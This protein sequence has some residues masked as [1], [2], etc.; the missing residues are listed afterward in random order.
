MH[1]RMQ[2]GGLHKVKAAGWATAAATGLQDAMNAARVEGFKA[3]VTATQLEEEMAEFESAHP[4]SAHS[5]QSV[6]PNRP[7]SAL[8]EGGVSAHSGSQ[9]GI[10][11]LW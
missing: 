3:I 6:T 1:P 8:R 10:G 11:Q 2:E 5:S 4:S 9:A 7:V